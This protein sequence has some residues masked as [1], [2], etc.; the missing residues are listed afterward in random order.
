METAV[1]GLVADGYLPPGLDLARV[2]VEPPRD[3]SHG[4]LSSNA[5]MVLA[6]PAGVKPRARLHQSSSHA[7]LLAGPYP[8]N[9]PP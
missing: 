9:A 5:A 7:G 6:K 2:A 8:G 1:N 3:P 4:D